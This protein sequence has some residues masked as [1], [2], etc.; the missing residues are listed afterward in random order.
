MISTPQILI[1]SIAYVCLLFLIAYTSDNYKP[2][3]ITSTKKALVY[4]FSLAVYCTS[5]TFYGAVGSAAE[6]GWGYLP[7][8]L[9]P[10]LMYT[11]G[12]S[13]I[14]RFVE[15]AHQNNS[16]SI[17]DFIASRYDKS[18]TIAK[19][20]T[21]IAMVATIPYIALQLKAIT[22]GI[23]AF[24]MEQQILVDQYSSAFY[25]AVILI[26]FSILFGTRHIIVTEHQYGMMN[27]IA[28][29]SIVK[30][31]AFLTVGLFALYH[32]FD[33][34]VDLYNTV[35]ST[36]HMK[37]LF[38]SDINYSNFITQ[39]FIAA[40]AIFC[41]PRQFHVSVVEYHQEKDLKYARFIFPSYLILFSLFI[42]PIVVA[43]SEVFNNTSVNADF[44]VLFLPISQGQNWLSIVSFIGGLSAATGMVIVATVTLSTMVSNDLILPNL[45]WLSRLN[46]IKSKNLNKWILSIRRISIALL[47]LGAYFFYRIIDSTQTLASFGLV[48]FSAV[49]QFAPAL[50][51]GM[52]WSRANKQ[53]ALAGLILGISSWLHLIWPTLD[54]A[55]PL[56]ASIYFSDY[57]ILTIAVLF[58]ILVNVLAIIFVSLNTRQSLAEKIHAFAF[59]QQKYFLDHETPQ[60][61][62][63]HEIRVGD[64]KS[65]V[66][67]IIG[68]K[69]TNSLYDE[70]EYLIVNENQIAD[71]KLIKFTEGILSR[72]IGAP[73][74]RELLL[75]AFKDRG[76]N[77]E[78]VFSLL[79]TA[80]Q[81]LKFN[82]KLLDI[83]MDNIS[84]G[85]SVI[86]ME[87]KLVGWN[88][89][90]VKLL[91]YPDN[92]L[93]IGMDVEVAIRFNAARGYCGP[94]DIESH[95]KK[96]LK[97]LDSGDNYHFE[98]TREDK[99]VI[100]IKGNLLPGGGYVTTYTDI[101]EYK[102][103]VAE[104]RYNE[105]QI[106]LYT[107]NSP[108][109]LAYI[110]KDLIFRFANKAFV[111]SYNLSKEKIIGQHIEDVIPKALLEIYQEYIDRAFVN[112]KQYFE[113]SNNGKK[114]TYYINTYIPHT[115]NQGDVMGI[116][117]VAQDISHRRKAELALQEINT[118]LENRVS[119]RTDELNNTVLALEQAKNV[120]EKAVQ[121]KSMF[122]AAASHDLLQPFNAA[123]LFCEI[124]MAE[125]SD[126][127]AHQ[128]DLIHKTNQSLNVAGNIISS[129]VEFIKLDGGN[130]IPRKKSFSL[131]EFLLSLEKQFSEL[132]TQKSI[133]IKVLPS[134][135]SVFSDPELLYRIFQNLISNA[136]RYTLNGR[137][138]IT[139]CV[140]GDQIRI[141]VWDTGV[142][143]EEAFIQDIFKEFKQF[144]NTNVVADDTGIGLGL[145]ISQKMTNMLGHEITVKS[146]L[147]KG[148]VFHVYVDKV[149][150]VELV[151]KLPETNKNKISKNSKIIK[152]L[153]VD[154]NLQTLDAMDELMTSWK[155]NIRTCNTINDINKIIDSEF[156]PEILILDYQLDNDQTGPEFL[157]IF[158]E[159][160]K[161]EIPA[162]FITAN[163][164]DDVKLLINELGCE[165]LYKPV[166]PAKLRKTIESV[167]KNNNVT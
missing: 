86:D 116:Y 150:N 38:F 132:A 14:K 37:N 164:A 34:P 50:V 36:P 33:G 69:N 158:C 76:L 122:M 35:I 81:A 48:S 154:N 133:A 27:A 130:I 62:P 104:L 39:T 124:L 61:I 155:Y 10:I 18:Q 41:L 47:L 16:T 68:Q 144:Y 126:M 137:I 28:F 58:S 160:V 135:H 42:I 162:I 87:N 98:R 74:A 166:K 141:S 15:I 65:I 57:S 128:L 70:Y 13:F 136:I 102:N 59:T 93:R 78:D 91:N 110:D 77:V 24:D 138:L 19:L 11:V 46:Y 2:R 6:T 89:S 161:K 80:S 106:A 32:I 64:L 101:T 20:V 95:V 73:S 107:D 103:I 147:G 60:Q 82:R 84:Q 156:F 111:Q 12:W 117:I 167:L 8:Y 134:K 66:S 55:S 100:E 72:I 118:T 25:V 149:E 5:W 30:L 151:N 157:T 92:F 146:E 75:Y 159:R 129:L 119:L 49:V 85:I 145:Y 88:N 105:Q 3:H 43:G 29:E 109:L 56:S 45:L 152:I 4:S 7:I 97:H 52:Y 17:S 67:I 26:V 112:Q 54:G 40:G 83:T 51:I 108:A 153:C 99:T 96:R 127:S 125:S 94:G 79:N 63:S 53:G 23:Q 139:N 22:I 123:R 115:L 121:T 131:Q 120:A 113:S 9:G 140:R 44:Y 1:I 71:Q 165:L 163:Y 114:I 90:Y 142:G 31:V 143:I 148:S 21:I